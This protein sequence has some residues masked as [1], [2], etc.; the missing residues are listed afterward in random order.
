[1]KIIGISGSLRRHS[2]NTGLLRAAVA[3]VPAGVELEIAA[4]D[5]IPLYNADVE[6]SEGIPRSVVALKDRIVAAD[7]LLL[8]TPEYNNSVSGVLK[9]AIDWL[10]RPSADS[11]RVFGGR[12]VAIMGASPGSYGSVQAQTAWLPIVRTLRMQPWFGGRLAVAHAGAAFDETGVLRDDKVRAQLR[13][14]VQGFVQ[15]AA[16]SHAL[17]SPSSA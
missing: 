7:A 2:F 4:I 8:S 13:D 12:L 16:A 3:L 10:S 15:F 5:E 17:K 1:M 9:N 14:F 11:Q 6:A